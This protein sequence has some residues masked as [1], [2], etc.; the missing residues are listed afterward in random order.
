MQCPRRGAAGKT[1]RKADE[2]AAPT[3]KQKFWTDAA[4]RPQK[5]EHDEL[6][7]LTEGGKHEAAAPVNPARIDTPQRAVDPHRGDNDDRPLA[8]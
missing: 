5:I 1:K 6:K 7:K 8:H 3:H 2:H 4:V